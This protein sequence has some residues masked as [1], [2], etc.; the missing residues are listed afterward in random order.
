[1]CDVNKL[2]LTA[3][4][5]HIVNQLVSKL[6][7][8]VFMMCDLVWSL[9]SVTQLSGSL[10]T[11]LLDVFIMTINKLT[12]VHVQFCRQRFSHYH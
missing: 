10:F 11:G 1:M 6:F 9:L 8:S 12:G 3:L 2:R 4:E 7:W 5:P